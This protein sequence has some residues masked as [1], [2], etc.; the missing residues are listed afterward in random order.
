MLINNS[1]LGV[2]Y[3]LRWTTDVIATSA[4]LHAADGGVVLSLSTDG[5]MA[6]GTGSIPPVDAF[7]CL[8]FPCYTDVHTADGGVA[9]APAGSGN[10]LLRTP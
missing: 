8:S 4:H 2:R 6:N 3:E 9:A 1:T 10:A 7:G 5:G